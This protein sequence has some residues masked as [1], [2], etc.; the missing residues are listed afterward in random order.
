MNPNNS[1]PIFFDNLDIFAAQYVV[2]YDKLK[3]Q[4]DWM[5]DNM[6]MVKSKEITTEYLYLKLKDELKVKP[7]W[8]KDFVVPEAL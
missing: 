6:V 4:Y 3:K 8:P 7:V 2:V 5:T 1:T